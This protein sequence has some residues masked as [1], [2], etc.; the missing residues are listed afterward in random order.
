[1]YKNSALFDNLRSAAFGSITGSYTTLGSVLSS[2]AVCISFANNT[3]AIIYVSTDGVNDMM[4]IPA[5]WGKVYD[6]R[7][8]APNM[9]DYLLPE[10]TQI[11]VKY[12]GS[13]PTSGSIYMEALILKP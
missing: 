6:I 1:M 13:A 10:L 4:A 12:S 11:Y 2:Q 8:N 3:D 7:T 9:T 5:G